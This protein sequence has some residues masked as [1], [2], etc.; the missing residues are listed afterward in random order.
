MKNCTITTCRA[1]PIA[2]KM[3]SNVASPLTSSRTALLARHGMPVSRGKARRQGWEGECT[4]LASRASRSCGS[5]S[6]VT[7]RNRSLLKRRAFT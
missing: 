6:C 3:A 2:A 7:S 1:A 5:I 4:T